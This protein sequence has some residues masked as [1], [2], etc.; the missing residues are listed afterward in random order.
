MT[1]INKHISKITLS[2]NDLNSQIKRYRLTE[3]IKKIPL[4]F[5]YKKLSFKDRYHLKVKG[6]KKEFQ[7]NRIKKQASIVIHISDKIRFPTKTKQDKQKVLNSYQGIN[8]LGKYH[9]AKHGKNSGIP[10][11]IKSTLIE[12]KAQIN[13][14]PI[15]LGGFNTTLSPGDS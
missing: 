10:N 6:Q 3:W 11:F 9:N 2:V 7:V 8:F 13:T 1:P 12:L 14:D 5:V 15:I 4:S